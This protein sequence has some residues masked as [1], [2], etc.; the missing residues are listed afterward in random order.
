MTLI[1]WSV[2]L[3]PFV[4]LCVLAGSAQESPYFVTYDHHMK[5]LATWTLRSQLRPM[6]LAPGRD[7]ISLHGLNWNTEL[8]Q[9]GRRNSTSKASPLGTTARSSPAGDSK[10]AFVH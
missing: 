8:P 2:T 6:S 9:D 4:L 10:T 1:K 3:C 7:S 5:S